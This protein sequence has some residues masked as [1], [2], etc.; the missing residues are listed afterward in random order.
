MARII[1]GGTL[2]A[3]V[4]SVAACITTPGETA[5]GIA[6]T[7][8]TLRMLDADRA[9]GGNTSATLT[10]GRD[11]SVAGTLACNSAGGIVGWRLGGEFT[12][13]DAPVII[14]TGGCRNQEKE[15]AIGNRF[16]SRFQPGSTWTL[17]G[18]TLVIQFADG[19]RAT[20]TH[21]R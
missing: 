19:G 4:L 21:H 12:G 17:S 13:L 18:D 3:A 9:P 14:T 20:F 16:W 8:W 2:A 10:F 5:G 11:G 1:G 7:D 15:I 6:G